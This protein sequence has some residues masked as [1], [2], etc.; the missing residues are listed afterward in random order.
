MSENGTS[1]KMTKQGVR[2]LGNTARPTLTRRDACFH[3]FKRACDDSCPVWY[4]GGSCRCD[5]KCR[6]CGEF[7]GG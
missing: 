1:P 7:R 6:K 4:G 5:Y 3:E 2:D